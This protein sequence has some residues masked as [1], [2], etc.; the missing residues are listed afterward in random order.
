MPRQAPRIP[1]V[2]N[3]TGDL[4]TDDQATDPQYWGEHLCRPVRFADGIRHCLSRGIDGYVEL[5]PGQVLGGLVRQNLTAGAA[6]A[7]LGT[8]PAPWPATGRPAETTSLLET[9]GRLWELGVRLDWAAL[10]PGPARLAS[11]P[12]Y[13]FQ[14]TRYWPQ[15]SGPQAA[16]P[17]QA[18]GRRQPTARHRHRHRRPPARRRCAS[19]PVLRRCLAPGPDPPPGGRPRPGRHPRDLR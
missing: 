8:L 16:R 3:A 11:L 13:P 1:V 10:R 4:L 2:S 15:A 7:V 19:R 18:A 5:G 6:P 17:G 9:C 14:R 12:A